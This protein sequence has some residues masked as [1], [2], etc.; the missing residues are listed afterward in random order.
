V[1]SRIDEL[2]TQ[3]FRWDGESVG[4]WAELL[5]GAA[6]VINLAGAPVTM[7]W[8]EE[9]KKEIVDSRV[10]STEAIGKAIRKCQSPPAVWINSSAVGYYGDRGDEMLTESS[11]AGEGFLSETC[12]AWERAQEQFETPQTRQVIIRTGVVL[13]RG[14]GAFE[15]LSKFTKRFLGG[16]QGSGRQWMPWIHLAD[17]CKVFSW[18]L[19]T[20][21]KGPLNGVGPNPMQNSDVMAAFRDVWHRPWSPPTPGFALE[22]VGA[23]IGV[24]AE[25]ALISQRAVPKALLDHGFSF[26]FSELS[27][28]L[29]DLVK[30]E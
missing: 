22:I 28:A 3:T 19:K 25:I 11:G 10:K 16:S 20:D 9:K 1:L 21:F 26:E 4:E 2:K 14:G 29:A 13:G 6:A 5:E 23:L 7:R 17:L 30:Q 18:T 15:E 8:T 12:L 27:G 24:Q